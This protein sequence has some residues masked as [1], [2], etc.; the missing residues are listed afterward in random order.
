MRIPRLVDR[1]RP[2]LVV[3]VPLL[4]LVLVI[5]LG[6]VALAES[7]TVG[8]QVLS[9]AWATEIW[10]G[11]DADDSCTDGGYYHWVLSPGAGGN[12]FTYI[13]ATLH[14]VYDGGASST[15]YGTL[16]GDGAMHFDVYDAPGKAIYAWV[17]FEYQGVPGD[18]ALAITQL[19]S[20]TSTTP[21]NVTTGTNVH[22]SPS[23]RDSPSAHDRSHAHDSSHA[24]DGP[25]ACES[26]SADES[27][28]QQASLSG[29]LEHTDGRV[30]GVRDGHGD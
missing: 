15:T 8:E 22:R 19:A 30:D 1:V 14:V 25:I 21:S 3:L 6:S 17:C 28:S 9:T 4:A 18:T 11:A 29:H 23:A 26:S 2:T 27:F 10:V 13:S 20:G 5:S 16:S 7:P 24:H 12:G